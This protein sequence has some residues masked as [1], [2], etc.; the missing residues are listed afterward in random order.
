MTR[1]KT[2]Q[3]I[4]KTSLYVE[5]DVRQQRKLNNLA[6]NLRAASDSDEEQEPEDED[7][8]GLDLV[9]NTWS[10]IAATSVDHTPPHDMSIL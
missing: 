2:W 7:I 8:A 1:S 9:I 6:P 3:D 5:T 4:T 10:A